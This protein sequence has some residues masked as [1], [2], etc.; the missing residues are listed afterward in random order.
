MITY[1][2]AQLLVRS[3]A[4]SFGTEIVSIDDCDG[5]VL[6][7]NIFADR[8][9]PPFNRSA[10]DGYAINFKD[11]ERGVRTFTVQQTIYAGDLISQNLEKG[12][13]FKIMTGAA[14][15][16]S[17]DTVIRRED[18]SEDNN[19]V[20]FIADNITQ[21]K[22]TAQKGEDLKKSTLAIPANSICS[23]AVIATLATLGKSKIRVQALPKVALFTTGN[24][25]KAINDVLSDVEIRNSNYYLLKSLL[26]QWKIVPLL[27]Q[28]IG[29]SKTELTNTIV[30]ALDLDII[31]L[32]GGV[33]AGDADY[34][35]EILESLGVKKIFHKVAIKPGKPIW[36]GKKPDGP[37]VFALPG[38]P[39]SSFVTFKLFI[40]TFLQKSL[41][42][43]EKTSFESYFSGKRQKKTNLDE[44]FPAKFNEQRTKLEATLI[45][46]SGDIRL[47][48]NADALILHPQEKQ[49]LS[50]GQ[51]VS[52]YP[53]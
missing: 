40:E 4:K 46:G 16:E 53:L 27:H 12:S 39:F 5:R 44:F 23:A 30:Q 50:D 48:I 19:Y 41:Q 25:V 31:I 52:Y 13:A 10:M 2:E 22:N 17:A 1:L 45:N 7:E 3:E 18:A 20:S 11:W 36:C 24:E 34:V 42:N 28:H 37:M 8:D 38:N 49:I 35:P 21:F 51:L 47:G 43:T 26:K 6:A 9:Y 15:P 14:I 29:D 33:S 32:S